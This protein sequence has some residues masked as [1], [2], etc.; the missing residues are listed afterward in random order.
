MFAAASPSG[1]AAFLAGRSIAHAVS[2][3]YDSRKENEYGMSTMC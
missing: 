1:L 2:V 3:V